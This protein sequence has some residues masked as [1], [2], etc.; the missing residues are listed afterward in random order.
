MILFVQVLILEKEHGHEHGN[1]KNDNKDVVELVANPI[2]YE[3]LLEHK[4]EL[5]PDREIIEESGK[6]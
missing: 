4:P 5:I 6:M 3:E 1:D 2:L